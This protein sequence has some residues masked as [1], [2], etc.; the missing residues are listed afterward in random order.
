M[1]DRIKKGL[2]AIVASFLRKYA[3]DAVFSNSVVKEAM[4][5]EK[6]DQLRAQTESELIRVEMEGDKYKSEVIELALPLVE[7]FTKLGQTL[8]ELLK[9]TNN[10]EER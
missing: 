2:G 8:K 5:K 3:V 9:S 6:L 1:E 7:G 4:S 10:K